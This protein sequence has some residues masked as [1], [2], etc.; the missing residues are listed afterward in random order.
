M[1]ITN[2]GSQCGVGFQAVAGLGWTLSVVKR[3]CAIGY[4]EF[5][6]QIGHLFGLYH[7]VE[8]TGPNPEYPT[9]NGFLM[10]PPANSGFRTIL[11]LVLFYP[12]Y[13]QSER[14]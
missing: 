13:H 9:A 3:D 2:R 5:G 12:C 10:R 1:I 6:H 4:Y 7:N 8:V 14:K 11:A